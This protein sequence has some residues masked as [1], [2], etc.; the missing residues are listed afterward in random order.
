MALVVFSS[1]HKSR[2]LYKWTERRYRQIYLAC[3]LMTSFIMFRCSPP[4]AN[5]QNI[6]KTQ[7]TVPAT[8]Q[9]IQAQIRSL[10]DLVYDHPEQFVR[11]P[12]SFL[13]QLPELPREQQGKY[14]YALLLLNMGYALRQDGQVLNSTRYYEKALDYYYKNNIATIDF[15]EY[16]VKPLGSLYTITGDFE[17][18]IALQ[19]QGIDKAIKENKT[20]LLPPLYGNLAITLQQ[21]NQYDAVRSVCNTGLQYAPAHSIVAARLYNEIAKCYFNEG[22][23]DSARNYNQ[24]SLSLFRKNKRQKETAIWLTSALLLKSEL[25]AAEHLFP[26]SLATITEAINLTQQYFPNDRNREKAKFYEKRASLYLQNGSLNAASTDYRKAID[27]FPLWPGGHF[28][29]NTITDAFSGMARYFNTSQQV[30]SAI[31]YYIK[32][33]ENDYIVQQFIANK[34]S[35]YYNSRQSRNTLKEAMNLLYTV[36]K[37]RLKDQEIVLDMLWITELSKGRQLLMEIN[38]T[39]QWQQDSANLEL[40]GTQKQLRYLYEEMAAELQPEKRE[41][42]KTEINNIVFRFQLTEQFFEKR[43][44]LPDRQQFKNE[45]KKLSKSKDILSWQMNE[46]GDSYA[47]F[48]SQEQAQV[49]ALPDTALQDAGI[50]TFMK[51]Y[52]SSGP[53]AFNNNPNEYYS[54]SA[55]ILST[56]IPDRS[57]LQQADWLIIPDGILHGLPLE[58]LH[59]GSQYLISAKNTSYTYSLLHYLK[60]PV[61]RLYHSTVSLFGKDKHNHHLS[62]L[63][64]VQQ[65]MEA[66]SSRY[67]SNVYYN[68]AATEASFIAAMNTPAVLHIATHALLDSQGIPYLELD[69][70][71]SLDKIQYTITQ[72]PLVVLSACQTASGKLITAEG[73]ESLNRIL[74]SKGVAGV[75]AAQW[76][77]DDAT[78]S[79]IIEAFYQELYQTQSP[80]IALANVK[81]HYVVEAPS[82]R[83]SNPWYWAALNY[84]GTP[85]MIQIEKKANGNWITGVASAILFISIL[86]LWRIRKKRRK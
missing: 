54:S 79:Q 43:F 72:T 31:V 12:D 24:L 33:I 63:K 23:R 17:K 35:N 51:T 1:I 81:R 60:E 16:L 45:A 3:S 57:L 82:I 27:L 71:V 30:D 41:R 52:F 44:D 67:V 29:D 56:L 9:D 83:L 70:K 84:T 48:L 47:L 77:V 76:P 49:F 21:L 66:I 10:G 13:H 61:S 34:E 26:S 15:Q 28:P 36:S 64:N 50:P 18:A 42:L 32:S 85:V 55:R 5:L 58:A 46:G 75:I 73:M 22:N 38:R 2:L 25:E 59:T 78:I 68:D 14:A 80:E 53:E 20:D 74:L 69:K 19:Q 86:S 6:P 11:N 7:Q 8:Q 62:D 37:K 39:E 40:A 65:E 4:Q